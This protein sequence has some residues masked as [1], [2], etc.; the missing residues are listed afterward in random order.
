MQSFLDDL[1][2]DLRAVEV[3]GVNVVDAGSD[4]LAQDGDGFGAVAGRAEDVGAGELHRAI[5]D[6]VD[7]ERRA[8]EVECTA[9]L[10]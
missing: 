8:G 6:A 4:R 10:G 1:V 3:A 7:G 2:G 5:A 9:E